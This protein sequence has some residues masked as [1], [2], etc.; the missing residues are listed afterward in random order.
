[1]AWSRIASSATIAV[2]L[3]GCFSPQLEPCAFRCGAGG[4]CPSGMACLADDFCHE[5]FEPANCVPRGDGSVGFA[6]ARADAPL[7]VADAR[8]PDAPL[9]DARPVPDAGPVPDARPIDARVDAPISQPDAAPPDAQIDARPIDAA[10]PD[11]APDCGE[12]C[13]DPRACEIVEGCDCG[14]VCFDDEWCG[15]NCVFAVCED[16]NCCLPE[17]A[18]CDVGLGQC[19]GGLTCVVFCVLL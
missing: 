15:A 17:G 11:A 7:V 16:G 2:V 9:A 4:A 18:T 12:V 8:P 14:N 5:P 10:I 1:L 13:S 6:D 3:A 19:C